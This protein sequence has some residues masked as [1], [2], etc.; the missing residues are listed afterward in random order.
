MLKVTADNPANEFYAKAGMRCVNTEQGKQRWL[1]VYEMNILNI[2]VRGSNPRVPEICR[3]SGSAYGVKQGHKAYDQ[4]FMLDVDFE[5]PN[6]P[7]YLDLVQELKPVQAL[8]I[9]Y[10]DPGLEDEMLTQ[11]DQLKKAGVLR[12]VV[13]VK[14]H[15]ATSDIPQDCIIGVSLRT[16]GRLSN[17]DN[18]YAGFMPDFRELSGRECHLLGG[19]PQLQ[20]DTIA[21][22]LGHGAKVISADGNA[23]FGAGSKGSTYYDNTWNRKPGE[24][25]NWYESALI[26]SKAIQREL[27]AIKFQQLSL[28]G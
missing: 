22:L 10:D 24:K 2:V 4:I 6:W 19:S 23:H 9:D 11:V 28:F 16:D 8:V 15:G 7:K 21:K 27:N 18:P 26:S 14:F 1:N 25:A 12:V 17:G 20:K 13:C 3:L 5:R